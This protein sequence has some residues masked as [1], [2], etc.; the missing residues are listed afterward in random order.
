[1]I[2]VGFEIIGAEEI[3]ARF[4]GYKDRTSEKVKEAI[5]R[6]TI[7]LE[8]YIKDQ[9]LSGQVLHNRSGARGLH[10][11][12]HSRFFDSDKGYVGI[13]GTDSPYARIH[14]LGF[15]GTENV[16]A[17]LRRL[18]LAGHIS[19]RGTWV[20]GRITGE[21]VEVRAF[22]RQMHMPM[23]SFLRTSLEENRQA[24]RETIAEALKEK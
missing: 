22:T 14:E 11:S 12:I 20:K 3:A 23:R 8:F 17:H 19:R 4:R 2:G 9:K 10:G 15:D 1:M 7:N 5:R 13:V 6:A 16:R 21:M 24:I 18:R